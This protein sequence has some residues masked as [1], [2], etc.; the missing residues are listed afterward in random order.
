MVFFYACVF[1][2]LLVIYKLL[3]LDQSPEK[4]RVFGR[5]ARFVDFVMKT[6]PLLTDG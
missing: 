3:H 6:C 4:P 5:D 1:V 2:A